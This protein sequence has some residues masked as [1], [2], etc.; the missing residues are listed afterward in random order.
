MKMSNIELEIS[1]SGITSLE[2]IGSIP[3]FD[4]CPAE[5]FVIVALRCLI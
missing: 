3:Y 2:S 5:I 1:K 4:N